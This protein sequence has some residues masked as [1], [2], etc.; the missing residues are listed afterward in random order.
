[1]GRKNIYRI[2]V[3]FDYPG[4]KKL[5]R[6][7]IDYLGTKN[8]KDEILI[9]EN[10][11]E[12][13]GKR[14]LKIDLNNIFYNHNNSLYVQILKTL[15][16]YYCEI[17]RYS[18]I[19]KIVVR[20]ESKSKLLETKSL[21][22]NDIIQIV[23]KNFNLNYKLDSK[24]LQLL[25]SQSLN[26]KSFFNSITHLIKSNDSNDEFIRFE[27]LW[28]SFEPLYTLIGKKYIHHKDD[29]SG[30]ECLVKTMIFV[31]KN[32]SSFYNS[33]PKVHNITLKELSNLSR[34][35][36]FIQDEFQNSNIYNYKE[37]IKGYKDYRVLNIFFENLDIMENKLTND[38]SYNGMEKSLS[39]S[40]NSE[41]E[42]DSD[43][44]SVLNIN[45]LYYVRN[46]FFHG[47]KIDSS[48]RLIDNKNLDEIKWL[49]RILEPF[50]I[51]LINLNY[52]YKSK[53]RHIIK[54]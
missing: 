1:M 36:S 2:L 3:Q 34:W 27:K 17:R 42:M 40:V 22:K 12:I 20:R 16:Y 41:E 18:E 30:K 7:E 4:N 9:N 38:E 45:Y 47:E 43:I 51:D 53:R 33:L 21:N 44:L 11:I 15:S 19:Q 31:T 48:F 6:G 49:N 13:I 14:S 37:T 25:F 46:K 35:R 10:F 50:I 54:N 5:Y 23:T 8:Y 52:K 32:S 29:P 26:G 39:K 28:K 24:S